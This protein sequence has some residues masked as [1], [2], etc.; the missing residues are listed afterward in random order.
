[1]KIL[2]EISRERIT[3]VIRE[4]F[5]PWV[6]ITLG[7]LLTCFAIAA[8]I[9]PYQFASTGVTGLGLITTY[10]WGISPV[11]VLSIGNIMLLVWGWKALSVRFAL[12]TLYVNV[13]MS[14][15]LA[16]FEI[17]TY[18][19]IH[20][21]ILAALLAGVVGGLG[22]G[23]LFRE[24]GSS[25]GMDVV[26]AVLKKRYG[27]EVGSAS[28]FVNIGILV[29]TFVAVDLERILMGGL[30]LYVESLVIDSVV[31][32]FNRRTQV[33]L[34]TDHQEEFIR[35]IISDLDRTATLISAKGSYLRKES[36]MIM[37]IL[38]RRQAVQLKQY[39]HE[40]DPN[41]FIIFSDVTEV[42]GYGFKKSGADI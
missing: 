20:N 8:L 36:E 21:T 10:L 32:S 27:I 42:V 39:V 29:L 35:F 2:K 19:I 16:F 5:K 40:T 6:N 17:F 4:E 15:S 1:M 24:G 22:M 33:L 11:W 23:I 18:P 14:V 37:V 13:L 34:I 9:E 26:S 38:T 12:W 28:F 31:K 30:V 7:T 41:A 25:G 3:A